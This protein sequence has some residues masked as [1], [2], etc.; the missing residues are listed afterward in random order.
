[1]TQSEIKAMQARIGVVAD[2]FWGPRSI[3][4][5]KAHLLRMMPTPNPWPAQDQ[6]SLQRFY[7]SPGD[8]STH[9]VIMVGGLDIRYEGKTIR[10]IQCHAKVAK[11]LERILRAIN[12]SPFRY[13][14]RDYNGCYNNRNMRNG[15]LPSLHARAA[16]VDF[17]VGS[18]GNATSWPVRASMPLEVMEIFAR[19]GWLSAGAFWGRDAM[20]FQAT[21]P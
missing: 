19:E 6:R 21:R 2:G 3:A 14:L 9:S 12:S 4:A 18:N 7:G 11:S 17:M 10:A 1:M 13:V 15:S 20:H 8:E 16:A 5:C